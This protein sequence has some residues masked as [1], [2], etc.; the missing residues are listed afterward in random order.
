[1]GLSYERELSSSLTNGELNR[2]VLRMESEE[3]SISATWKAL[4]Y[5]ASVCLFPSLT[6]LQFSNFVVASGQPTVQAMEQ[7]IARITE[8]SEGVNQ[9]VWISLREEPLVYVNGDPYCLRREAFSLR[10][11]KG[12]YCGLSSLT[13]T[14]TVHHFPKDYGGISASRLELL[15]ERLKGDIEHELQA[16]GGRLLLHTESGEGAVVPIWEEVQPHDVALLK[17]VMLQQKVPDNVRLQYYRIPIT[18][19]RPPDFSD[20]SDLMEVVLKNDTEFGAIVVNCQLGRGRST[21]TSVCPI[22][23]AMDAKLTVFSP[24]SSST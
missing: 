20:I 22:V 15:E 1:V 24:R 3:P 10:N 17:D 2:A 12:R 9:I 8:E 23:I 5:T 11:M 19:E 13:G 16:F 18:S 21:L 4:T 7:V 6:C 14:L